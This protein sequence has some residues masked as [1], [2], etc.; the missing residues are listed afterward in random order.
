MSESFN[1][2]YALPYERMSA[3]PIRMYE[4]A[5]SALLAVDGGIRDGETVLEVGSGTANS[6][7]IFATSNPNLRRLICV[8][9]S[10]FINTAAYKLGQRESGFETTDP[11]FNTALAYIEQQRVRAEPVAGKI[12]LIKAR[13]PFLPFQSGVFDRA[14]FSQS[15]HW[16]AFPNEESPADFEYLTKGLADVSSVLK[17]GGRILFDSNGHIF[18]FGDDKFEGRSLKDIHYVNHPLYQTF[19]RNF[20]EHI[21]RMGYQIEQSAENPPDRLRLIFNLPKLQEIFNKARLEIIPNQY[22]QMYLLTPV[23]FSA[24]RIA[25]SLKD[26]AMMHHFRHPGLIDLSDEEK[27]AI[28]EEVLQ[29]TLFENPEAGSD[30]YF[31]TLISFV[32]QKKS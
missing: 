7:I 14:Y 2:Q 29:K 16:L 25:D 22:G 1:E 31:E 11:K 6:S 15:L 8:E 27:N 13:S 3:T 23:P 4:K 9:P 12:T 5:A 24:A 21:A 10:P 30:D 19:D 18:D 20:D 32:A 26:S 17:P 28:V